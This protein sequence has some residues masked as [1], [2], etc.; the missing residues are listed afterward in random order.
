MH[1][2]ILTVHSPSL[3]ISKDTLDEYAINSELGILH[4]VPE[5]SFS[6]A[7]CDFYLVMKMFEIIT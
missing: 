4:P 6:L 5:V 3:E 2:N 1:W 7:L